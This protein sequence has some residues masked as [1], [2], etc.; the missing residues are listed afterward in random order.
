MVMVDYI[1]I[2]FTFPNTFDRWLYTLSLNIYTFFF[3]SLYWI[4][5]SCLEKNYASS[6]HD[7]SKG[8]RNVFSWIAFRFRKIVSQER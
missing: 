5:F 8:Y 7:S 3:L 6:V 4:L 2:F 1:G